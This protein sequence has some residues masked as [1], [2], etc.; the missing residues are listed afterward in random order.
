MLADQHQATLTVARLTA[1]AER[2]DV[3]T[4]SLKR[5]GVGW[6]GG[7]YA[8]PMRNGDGE[9]IGLRVRYSS[10]AQAA[11]TGS[12]NGLFIPAGLSVDA[13]LLICEG[14]SDTA[15]A[16]DLGFGAVGRPSCQTGGA[17]LAK[18]TH[19]RNVI[20]VGDGDGPGRRGAEKLATTL[21][22]VCKS[23]RVIYPPDRIKDLRQWKKAGL[24]PEQ[25]QTTIEAASVRTVRIRRKTGK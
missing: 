6:G 13:L 12:R 24:T 21:V 1:L 11:V 25:L 7:G 15:A 4:E 2:L 16:L 20:I 22:L 17:M 9:I 3:S 23:V 18:L 5:L 14:C 8:F 10:G 19:G